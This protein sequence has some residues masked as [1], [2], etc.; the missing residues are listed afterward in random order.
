MNRKRKIL[1]GFGAL[2]VFATLA[3]LL[4]L[5]F[6]LISRP[7]SGNFPSLPDFGNAATPPGPNV[8]IVNEALDTCPGHGPLEFAQQYYE[9]FDHTRDKD[10]YLFTATANT[11][12]TIRLDN[13]E[14]KADT[15]LSLFVTG[16]A[17]PNPIQN[18]N[19]A[20]NNPD[21]GSCITWQAP[22]SGTYHIYVRNR[23]WYVDY[24]SNTGYTLTVQDD[25]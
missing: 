4:L 1:I 11:I 15:M 9:D 20:N 17:D 3:C 10:W 25:Q 16:C 19:C 2:V 6:S 5:L 22:H 18:D 8:I 13:L 14:N 23:N 12:Y 24:G 7:T 21:S